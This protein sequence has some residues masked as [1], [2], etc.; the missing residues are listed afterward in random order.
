MTNE[1]RLAE[2]GEWIQAVPDA[3]IKYRIWHLL[4]LVT[5]YKARLAAYALEIK[6]LQRSTV[7]WNVTTKVDGPP[8]GSTLLSESQYTMAA[9]IGREEEPITDDYVAPLEEERHDK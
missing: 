2:I 3:A 7:I 6:A 4:E 9:K 8:P 5:E 1:E